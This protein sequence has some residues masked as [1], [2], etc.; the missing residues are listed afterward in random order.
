M[1]R[2]FSFQTGAKNVKPKTIYMD[3]GHPACRV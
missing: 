1:D 3:V 2:M